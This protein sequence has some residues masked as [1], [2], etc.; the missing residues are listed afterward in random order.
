MC[1]NRRLKCPPPPPPPPLQQ[2]H[3]KQHYK[4]QLLTELIL[5]TVGWSLKPLKPFKLCLMI[6]HN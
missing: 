1:Q 5:H 3:I 2:F 6:I 4:S